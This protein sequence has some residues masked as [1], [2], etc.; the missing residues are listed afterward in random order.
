MV[1]EILQFS[2]VTIQ[3]KMQLEI[4]YYSMQPITIPK[5]VKIILFLGFEKIK[6][7]LIIGI[8]TYRK[9]SSKLPEIP[10]DLFIYLFIDSDF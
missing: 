4:V 5:K 6:N 9:R 3:L 1:S 8:V 2:L 7:N 10:V